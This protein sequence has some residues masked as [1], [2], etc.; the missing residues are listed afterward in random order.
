MSIEQRVTGWQW[1]PGDQKNETCPSQK[2]KSIPGTERTEQLLVSVTLNSSVG[3]WTRISC[4]A[5]PWRLG[6][7]S[8]RLQ[9]CFLSR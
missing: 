5:V 9:K 1:R 3:K 6:Q 7:A 2:E 8:Y 4:R